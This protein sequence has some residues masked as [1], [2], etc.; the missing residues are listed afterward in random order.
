MLLLVISESV[1]HVIGQMY[2]GLARLMYPMNS[3]ALVAC[4]TIGHTV[5]NAGIKNQ[6][7]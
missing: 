2:S 4:H 1:G 6:Y 7:L 5:P 3:Q